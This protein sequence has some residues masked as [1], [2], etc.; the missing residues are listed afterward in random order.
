[1]KLRLR[2]NSIRLRLTRSEVER[3][4][5]SGEVRESIDL[6][7]AIGFI[8]EIRASDIAADLAA[9][10]ADACLC[11]QI[12]SE[13]ANELANSD[14]ISVEAER[15]IGGGRLV[16]IVVEKD[17]ACLKERANGDDADTFPNPFYENKC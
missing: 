4:A 15:E 3:L 16:R 13:K 6:G 10:F 14:L 9:T 7:E 17:F 1:M 11:V 5:A 12:S 2:G 8:Y